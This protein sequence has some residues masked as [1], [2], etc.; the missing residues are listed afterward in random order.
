MLATT[1]FFVSVEG[2]VSVDI[3]S[4][5][6][7]ISGS[8]GGA[9]SSEFFNE[10]TTTADEVFCTNEYCDFCEDAVQSIAP[11]KVGDVGFGPTGTLERAPD[12]ANQSFAEYICGYPIDYRALMAPTQSAQVGAEAIDHAETLADCDDCVNELY[13]SI[14]DVEWTVEQGNLSGTTKDICLEHLQV[15]INR[16]EDI[17]VEIQRVKRLLLP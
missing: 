11:G 10:V 12:W 3:E 16:L 14:E 1:I 9:L 8:I 6:H 17:K 4:V 13:T 15:A 5:G 7:P 2:E